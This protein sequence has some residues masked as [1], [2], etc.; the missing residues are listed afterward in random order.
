GNVG[1]TVTA[2]GGTWLVDFDDPGDGSG[3]FELEAGSNGYASQCDPDNDCTQIHWQI[4]NPQFQVDPS[5]ENIWGNQFEPNSDLT[6]TVDDVG[7]PGSPHG[8]DEGGNFGIGFDPTTLNLTA[9]DVVSVF[10]GTTTKF[11][12]ITNLTITGVDH[13]SDTVSGMAEPG[14][15]VDVWDHGSGAWLQVVACDDSPEYPCNGDD[16]GTWHADFNS[17][18]DLVAGSNGNSAQCDD[19]NDCTFAGWWVVNPQ[20]QVSPAD[21]NIW[22]NEWEPK[23]L[24][25]ITV[26]SEEYG[27]YG[28]DEWGT[29]ETGFDP[30]ELDLQFGQTVTV[31]DGTTTKFH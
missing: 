11:H 6:I 9:G 18:A 23:G 15:N 20:F 3:T 8:T 29:F 2:T 22:G 21:E 1:R 28:I 4:P 27:P 30:A 24:V 25:T 14:S 26:N 5:S 19:D 31:S 10:D 7:V 17:Q 12:T 13:S 16:P